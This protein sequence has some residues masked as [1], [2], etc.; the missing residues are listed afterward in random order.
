MSKA[1]TANEADILPAPTIEVPQV[2]AYPPPTPEHP[3]LR[4]E[5]EALMR[6]WPDLLKTHY[7]Q[8][9]AIHDGQV[10]ESGPDKIAVA[11]SAYKRCGY[12]PIYIHL[13]TDQPQ[14]VVRI[15]S[16][17]RRQIEGTP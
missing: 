10:V 11:K 2:P 15:P 4:Q 17:G 8:Y 5:H 13:V 16:L 6:M 3:K 12:I 1:D 14:P 9:V 7:G